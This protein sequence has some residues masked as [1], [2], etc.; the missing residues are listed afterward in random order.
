MFDF[1]KLH[2]VLE[3]NNNM[4]KSIEVKSRATIVF[5]VNVTFVIIIAVNYESL[6]ENEVLYTE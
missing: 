1:H 4:R 5:C 2:L 6:G 3:N